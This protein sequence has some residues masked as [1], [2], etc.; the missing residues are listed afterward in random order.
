[1]SP[2]SDVVAHRSMA[3][4]VSTSPACVLQDVDA[5]EHPV[6]QHRPYYADQDEYHPKDLR[7]RSCRHLVTSA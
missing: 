6:S 2:S 7:V 1:M 5:E 4:T 3:P